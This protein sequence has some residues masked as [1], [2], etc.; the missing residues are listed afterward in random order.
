MEFKF[1][2]GF[3][4][5]CYKELEGKRLINKLKKYL[6]F[7][8]IANIIFTPMTIGKINEREDR[9][10]K[11][12]KESSILNKPLKTKNMNSI[13][14]E[15]LIIIT[16]TLKEKLMEIKYENGKFFF[17]GKFNSHLEGEKNIDEIRCL[18]KKDFNYSSKLEGEVYIFYVNEE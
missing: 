9:R 10:N 17:K 8:F 13:N 12:V 3:I 18:L 7:F 11:K 4:P 14:I 5:K 16:S 1:K 15:N 2:K 6:Y